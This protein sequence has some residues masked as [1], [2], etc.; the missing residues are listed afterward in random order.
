[1]LLPRFSW[2]SGSCKETD[3]QN[4]ISKTFEETTLEEMDRV[5]DIN[6]R[7]T[8]KRWVTLEKRPIFNRSYN[9][10]TR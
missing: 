3:R 1:M 9:N 10:R 8:V 5:I 2:P 4:A 7:G 6:V